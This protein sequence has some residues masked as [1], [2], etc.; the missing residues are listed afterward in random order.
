MDRFAADDRYIDDML[1]L[2]AL[3]FGKLCVVWVASP[4]NFNEPVEE[5]ERE[6]AAKQDEHFLFPEILFFSFRGKKSVAR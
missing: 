3:S 5:S 4:T 1:L 6:T 2:V